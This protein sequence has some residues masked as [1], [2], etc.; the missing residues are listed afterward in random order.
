MYEVLR[1]YS[2]AHNVYAYMYIFIPSS[3]HSQCRQGPGGSSGVEGTGPAPGNSPDVAHIHAL[4]ASSRDTAHQ[5]FPAIES[6]LLQKPFLVSD[7]KSPAAAGLTSTFRIAHWLLTP[8]FSTVF[9]PRHGA[10]HQVVEATKR[11]GGGG[12]RDRNQGRE[13]AESTLERGGLPGDWLGTSEDPTNWSVCGASLAGS[14]GC[15]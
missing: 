6:R 10:R 11:G 3:L 7:T 2:Y 9:G 5:A 12:W 13:G 14:S 15:V 4:A 8:M 1:T